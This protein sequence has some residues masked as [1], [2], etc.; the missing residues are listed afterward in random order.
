MTHAQATEILNIILEIALALE[1]TSLKLAKAA[2]RM[3]TK[4]DCTTADLFDEALK[5][6][7][8]RNTDD[9]VS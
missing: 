2:S 3:N 4:L 1:D 6:T 5:T 7:P 9:T 8:H